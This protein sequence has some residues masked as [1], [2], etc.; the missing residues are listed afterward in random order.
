[1]NTHTIRNDTKAWKAQVWISFLAAAALCATCL[2]FLPGRDLD[3]AFMVMGYMSCLSAPFT[4][5]KTLPDAHDG[6]LAE[7]RAAHRS[8]RA[9]RERV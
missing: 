4:L 8:A 7:A 9:E 2:A 3:R 6:A 1:M 5:A